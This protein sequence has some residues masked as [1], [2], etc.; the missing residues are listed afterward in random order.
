MANTLD[1]WLKKQPKKVRDEFAEYEWKQSLMDYKEK[2][3]EQM[4]FGNKP[5]I[6]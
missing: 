4:M 5:A 6:A 2:P 1:E 3:V